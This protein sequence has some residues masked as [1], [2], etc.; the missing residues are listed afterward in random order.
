MRWSGIGLR[1]GSKC[2]QNLYTRGWVCNPKEEELRVLV[3]LAVVMI[4]ACSSTDPTAT[5]KP[6]PTPTEAVMPSEIFELWESM[7]TF[8]DFF[9]ENERAIKRCLASQDY[10]YSKLYG[11][12]LTQHYESMEEDLSD[13][14]LDEFTLEDIEESVEN[15]AKMMVGL[16]GACGIG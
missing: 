12:G 4:V 6:R 11:S 9:A 13:G 15:L 7:E 3:I 10:D 8:N 16:V 2:F 1:D 14:R 5:A